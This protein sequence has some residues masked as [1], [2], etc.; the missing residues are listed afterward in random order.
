MLCQN[1]MMT[2]TFTHSIYSAVNL[3]HRT[4][5]LGCD[6]DEDLLNAVVYLCYT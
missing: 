6:A 2:M 5:R 3:Y 1:L 4:C